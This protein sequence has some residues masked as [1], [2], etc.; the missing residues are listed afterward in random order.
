MKRQDLSRRD[1]LGGL[2]KGR[3]EPAPTPAAPGKAP[4]RIAPMPTGIIPLRAF[5]LADG[6]A[7]VALS[8]ELAVDEAPQPWK[9]DR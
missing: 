2:L 1:L 4:G 5:R 7:P 8:A 6:E 3:G 9:R